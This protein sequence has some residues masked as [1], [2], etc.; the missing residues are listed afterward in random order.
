MDPFKNATDLAKEMRTSPEYKLLTSRICGRLNK[1][2]LKGY[3]AKKKPLMCERNKK[4]T[5]KFVKA[6]LHWTAEQ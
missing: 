1:A 3:I 6:H 5:L 4:K 2:G